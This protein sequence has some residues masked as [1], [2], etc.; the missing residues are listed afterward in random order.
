[1][2]NSEP[3]EGIDDANSNSEHRGQATTPQS[4]LQQ[5]IVVENELTNRLHTLMRAHLAVLENR[6]FYFVRLMEIRDFLLNLDP[7]TVTEQDKKIQHV[8]CA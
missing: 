8:K 5:A 2:D 6:N 4:D 1:M 7:A 3:W